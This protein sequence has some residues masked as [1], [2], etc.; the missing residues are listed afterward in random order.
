MKNFRQWHEDNCFFRE[1]ELLFGRCD[2]Q[3][4]INLAEILLVTS[5]TAVQDYHERGLTY[6]VLLENGFAILVSRTSFR[7]EKMPM[8]N[9]IITIKTW[10]EAPAGLQLS[11]NY[12]IL[13]QE[14]QVLVYGA[15]LWILVDPKTRRIIKPNQ[16]TLRELPSVR[17]DFAGIPCG[18]IVVPEEMQLLDERIIRYSDLDANGH[19][20]N[21]RYGAYIM[22]CMP[23]DFR[24]KNI[25]NFRIN[26]SQE[27]TLGDRLQLMGNFLEDE[28]V[29]IIGKTEKATCFEA[30]IYY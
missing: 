8:A 11:R 7:I 19:M 30:E 27:A 14:G 25:R 15:S 26:Y 29:V 22:D 2:I 4:R 1:E 23:E 9:D 13:N 17:T 16:F 18:K 20:N 28:K 12:E 10:E 5:D 6:D 3:H 24:S 21:S